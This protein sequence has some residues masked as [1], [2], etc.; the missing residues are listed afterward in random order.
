[1][2]TVFFVLELIGIVAFA[3]SGAIVARKKEMDILKVIIEDA[4]EK[5]CLCDR[6]KYSINNRERV[7]GF[8]KEVVLK[9]MKKI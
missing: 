4:L 8:S 1:M 3:W 9:E 2:E 7:K 5:M 6:Q